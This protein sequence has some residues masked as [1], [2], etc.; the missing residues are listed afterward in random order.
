MVLVGRSAPSEAAHTAIRRMEDAGAEVLVLRGDVARTADVEAILA[1]IESSAQPLRGIVHAAGVLDDRTLLDLGENQFWTPVRPKVLGAWNLHTATRQLPLDFFVMYSSVAGLLGSRGQAAYSAANTFLDA[2]SHAR[3]ADG[4]T[5]MSLQ[6]G[7]F[8]EVGLAA[9]QA[10][11]GLRMSHQG[12]ASFTPEE[13]TAILSRLLLRPRAEVGLLRFSMRQWLDS[14]PQASGMRFFTDLENE[15]STPRG[16]K[17]GTFRQVLEQ[18][19]PGERAAQLQEHLVEQLCRV[20]RLDS[21]RVDRRAPFTSLGMDSLMSLELR[22]RLEASLGLRLSAAL[23]F[24]YASP[25]ALTDY[26]LEAL[27]PP[28]PDAPAITVSRAVEGLA[29]TSITDDA[30]AIEQLAELEEFL[31]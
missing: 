9:E 28:P 2:L 3:T 17:A 20:L 16:P 23:L 1:R 19:V 24:T 8:A 12:I 5:A 15:Q 22:N 21:T 29:T 6:W 14:H 30:S 4:L 26:L 25:A 7:P 31:R 27:N 11:R 13:G 18:A 10:N